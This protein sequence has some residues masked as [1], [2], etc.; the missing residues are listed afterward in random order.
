MLA[1]LSVGFWIQRARRS[2]HTFWEVASILPVKQDDRLESLWIHKN[3]LG[4]DV[5]MLK[6]VFIRFKQ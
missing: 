1:A 6:N 3:I 4:R 2:F 5:A